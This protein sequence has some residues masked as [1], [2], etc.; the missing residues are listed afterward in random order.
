[1]TNEIQSPNDRQLDNSNISVRI[2]VFDLIVID[3]ESEIG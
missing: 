1:M 2:G 3:S